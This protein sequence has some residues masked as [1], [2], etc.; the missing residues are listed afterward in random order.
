MKIQIYAIY[1]A[2][3]QVY[4]TPHWHKNEAVAIRTFRDMT[5]D[6]QTTICRNPQDYTLFHMGEY[7]DQTGNIEP[8][9]KGIPQPV[10]HA[11]ALVDQKKIT[12]QMDIVEAIEHQ[13]KLNQQYEQHIQN[14][15]EAINQLL[16]ENRDTKFAAENID[17]HLRPNGEST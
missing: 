7:D 15:D 1:D 3:A 12:A 4:G 9:E 14:Q 6:H 16:E 13:K 17:Q 2:L 8:P 11:A 5:N 10:A